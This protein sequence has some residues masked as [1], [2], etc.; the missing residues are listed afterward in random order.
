[1]PDSPRVR[2]YDGQT[3]EINVAGERKGVF[4]IV[5]ME[6]DHLGNRRPGQVVVGLVAYDIESHVTAFTDPESLSFSS[7]NPGTPSPE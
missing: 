4:K 6:V 5:V 1:M 7:K 3:I 2:A